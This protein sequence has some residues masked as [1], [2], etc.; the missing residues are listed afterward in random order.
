MK[1]GSWLPLLIAFVAGAGYTLVTDLLAGG[2]SA[3]GEPSTIETYMA[4]TTRAFSIPS[5]ARKLKNPL[6]DSP[7]TQRDARLHFAD[8]CAFCHGNDGSGETP[9]GRGLYPKPPDLRLSATQRLPDGELFWVIE[10]GVRLTGMPAFGGEAAHGS[11]D[12]TWKLVHFI[13]HLPA[14]TPEERIEME[15]YNPKGPDERQEELDE[16]N[17]LNGG[18]PPKAPAGGG[19]E[20]R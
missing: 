13:R 19:Q 2:L 1:R 12:D 14:L 9:I 7:G 10:N 5:S 15:K 18:E 20:P 8:H 3:R 11:S 4:R 16:E 17:F 6:P